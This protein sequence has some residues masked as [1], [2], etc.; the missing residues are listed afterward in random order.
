[1]MSDFF[2]GVTFKS[3]SEASSGFKEFKIGENNA[4]I[5]K[6][7]EKKSGNGK[8][9]LE[10]TFTNDDGATIRYRISD[11]DWKLSMLKGL[12]LAF[13]ITLGEINTNKWI[14]KWGIVVCKAGEPYNGKV[15]NEVHYVKPDTDKMPT[16]APTQSAPK[17]Q[18]DSSDS[19]DNFDDDI[20]F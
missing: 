17:S 5:S 12:C 16:D 7:E 8:P 13:D 18:G 10:I 2:N 20:P 14:G 11:G 6:V 9:M 15:Y 1:M 19:F 3:L 4:Y